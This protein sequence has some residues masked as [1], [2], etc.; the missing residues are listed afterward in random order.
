MNARLARLLMYA[1]LALGAVLALVPL[2]WMVS[3]SFMPAGQ[4]STY[5]PRLIPRG[6]TLEHYRALFTRLDLGRSLLNSALIAVTV[7]VISRAERPSMK[8]LRE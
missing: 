6:A 4:A 7:T 5:P 1:Q 3:A 8:P 2:F